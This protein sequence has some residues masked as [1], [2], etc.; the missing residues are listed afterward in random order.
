MLKEL[1]AR[2]NGKTISI[3]KQHK[4]SAW[5]FSPDMLWLYLE[6]TGGF[7]WLVTRTIYHR[8]ILVSHL[9][10]DQFREWSEG[11]QEE[12]EVEFKHLKTTGVVTSTTMA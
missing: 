7:I 3:F 11:R 6:E 1:S 8:G 12:E 5:V 9:I 2:A 4:L 10:W